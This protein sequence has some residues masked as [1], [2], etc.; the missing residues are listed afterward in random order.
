MHI[1]QLN[2]EKKCTHHYLGKLFFFRKGEGPGL[3]I[4]VMHTA[5]F[6]E[7]LLQSIYYS[8]RISQSGHMNQPLENTT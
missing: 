2:S 8:L 1:S 4:K 5:I 3:C 6:I 7:K